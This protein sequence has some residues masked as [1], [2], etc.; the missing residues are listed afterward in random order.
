MSLNDKN[1]A[2]KNGE[3]ATETKKS[4]FQW[5]DWAKMY[6]IDFSDPVFHILNFLDWSD[7]IDTIVKS[8]MF[9]HISR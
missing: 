8:Q 2:E 3:N 9:N 7:L 5:Q 4:E 6:K 1:E